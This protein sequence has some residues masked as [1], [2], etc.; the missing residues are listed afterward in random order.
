MK[1]SIWAILLIIGFSSCRE[2]EPVEIIDYTEDIQSGGERFTT[3]VRGENVFGTQSDHLTHE[4]SRLF[5]SGNSLFRTNWVSAP[6]SVMSLDGLGPVFNAISCGSCHFKDGRAAPPDE[7]AVPKAGLLFRLSLKDLDKNGHPMPHPIYGG[8][9]QD[10][11]LPV[12]APEANVNISYE[13]IQGGY[14]DGTTYTLRKPIYTFTDWGYG[15]VTEPIMVSPRIAPQIYGL[16]LLENIPTDDIL[17]KEDEYDMDNDGI[18]GKAN[19]IDDVENGGLALGRFDWKANKPNIRQQAAGAFAGDMG[20]TSHLF[21]N[22]DWTEA[23][24]QQYPGIIDGGTPEISDDQLFRVELYIQ[25]LAVPAAR[26]VETDSYQAGKKLFTKINCAACHTPKFTTGN[27][28]NIAALN[29]QKIRPY[30]DLLLHDMGPELADNKPDGKATGSE[31]RTPPL[32]GL[33]LVPA[34]NEHTRYLHDG[35]ARSLEEAILWHGGEAKNSREQFKTL[36]KEEREDLLF[37]LKSI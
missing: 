17:R 21:P 36:T 26:D 20:L 30:T 31:W 2:D 28:A 15:P 18:S 34:V 23:Q 10:R 12:A 33:G 32:W 4:E 13:E 37:F 25:A 5:V 24:E 14:A 35:R 19:Y 9:L 7:F 27:N 6:S 11:S 3:F 16:G 22:T 1:W 29:N 8:Q